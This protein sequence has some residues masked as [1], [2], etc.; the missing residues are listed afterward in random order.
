MKYLIRIRLEGSNIK[1]DD[2]FPPGILTVA[3]IHLERP[4]DDLDR[5]M[6]EV[7]M[8]ILQSLFS[9]EFI[10]D[11]SAGEL[12]STSTFEETAMEYVQ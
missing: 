1:F 8:K 6:Q 3:Q 2:K 9:I 5:L 12:V 7:K 11:E 10:E 4:S